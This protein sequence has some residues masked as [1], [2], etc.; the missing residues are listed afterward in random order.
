[1]GSFCCSNGSL[2]VSAGQKGPASQRSRSHLTS[3]RS[4][5][6]THPVPRWWYILRS[7]SGQPRRS[8]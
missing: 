5:S 4:S 1:M 3:W 2:P 8:Q 7:D 6:A